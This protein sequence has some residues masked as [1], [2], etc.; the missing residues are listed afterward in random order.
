MF[1]A[2]VGDTFLVSGMVR[3]RVNVRVGFGL[4]L[5]NRALESATLS[6]ASNGNEEYDF[7]LPVATWASSMQPLRRDLCE[8]VSSASKTSGMAA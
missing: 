6:D 8:V 4:V 7:E 3:V 1:M 2:R 5:R